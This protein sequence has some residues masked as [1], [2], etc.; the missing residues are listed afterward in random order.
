MS[1]DKRNWFLEEGDMAF[2]NREWE[3]FLSIGIDMEKIAMWEAQKA[4]DQREE[5]KE[6][7]NGG[8]EGEKR[9]EARNVNSNLWW[10]EIK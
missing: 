5:R 6:Q 3:M 8:K 9:S 1:L 4:E 7:V 10:K 2:M